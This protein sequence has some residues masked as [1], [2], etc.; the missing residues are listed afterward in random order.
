MDSMIGH[1]SE[2]YWHF[3]KAAARI[4]DAA[5]FLPA[6]A[7]ALLLCAGSCLPGLKA[8]AQQAWSTWQKDGS[9]HASP[10]AGQMESAMAGA[11]QVRLGGT[12]FYDG[13]P[14]HGPEMGAAYRSPQVAD[15]R[16][17]LKLTAA[18]SLFGFAV[19]LCCL[20]RKR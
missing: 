3:G 1:T 16:R 14:I 18:A 11:L 13:Q 10:N 19:A 7:S 8:N 5:N 2:R 15:A 17:A 9:K 20:S 4:D 12:N 6:R